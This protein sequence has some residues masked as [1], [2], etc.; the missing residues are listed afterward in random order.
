MD[1]FIFL[2]KKKLIFY[3]FFKLFVILFD[4]SYTCFSCLKQM[5]TMTYRAFDQNFCSNLCMKATI[6]VNQFLDAS[7]QDPYK[8]IKSVEEIDIIKKQVKEEKIKNQCSEVL[9]NIIDNVSKNQISDIKPNTKEPEYNKNNDI[10]YFYDVPITPPRS[11][12]VPSDHSTKHSNQKKNREICNLNG[13][14]DNI[15]FPKLGIV[16]YA[17]SIYQT[18]IS[19]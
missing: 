18:L 5:E 3:F 9:N 13:L 14:F 16:I 17:N 1:I 12:N 11:P 2:Y 7:F 10:K 6:E 15:A 19:S 8:W 4:M